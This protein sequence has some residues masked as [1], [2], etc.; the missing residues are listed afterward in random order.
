G[1][2]C[3]GRWASA[4]ADCADP[5]G[6][7]RASVANCCDRMTHTWTF[8]TCNFSDALLGLTATDLVAGHGNLATNCAAEWAVHNP[9]NERHGDLKGPDHVRQRCMDGDAVCDGDGVVNGQCTV[10]VAVCLN[11]E[12]PRLPERDGAPACLPGGVESWSTNRHPPDGRE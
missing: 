7:G 12:D 8:Q 6:S 1:Q 10:S 11:V 9:F 2:L 5:P 3:G 4:V